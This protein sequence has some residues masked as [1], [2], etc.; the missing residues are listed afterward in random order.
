MKLCKAQ[1]DLTLGQDLSN[2]DTEIKKPMKGLIA[3]D[4]R[5][6][7]VILARPG[8]TSSRSLAFHLCFM[9]SLRY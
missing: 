9:G 2:A 3:P 5:W 7:A 8:D 4:S 6:A 1:W